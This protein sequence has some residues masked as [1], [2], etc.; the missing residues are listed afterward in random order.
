M[1][2]SSENSAHTIATASWLFLVEKGM[3]HL[4]KKYL[5]RW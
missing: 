3:T 2:K 5:M 1:N 4:M